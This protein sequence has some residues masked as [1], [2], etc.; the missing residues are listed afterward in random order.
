MNPRARQDMPEM[1]WPQLRTYRYSQQDTGVRIF[2]LAFPTLFPTGLADYSLPRLR[3]KGLTFL[4]WIQHLLRYHD[5]RFA[6]HD[7]FRY[8]AF[9]LW[10]RELS[11]A[12][13]RWV[14]NKHQGQPVSVDDLLANLD[15][16][17]RF[18]NATVRCAVSIKGTRPYWKR[19]GVELSAH[20]Q[21]CLIPQFFFTF[22]AADTQWDSLARQM[23]KYEEWKTQND[24]IR[25]V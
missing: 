17:Q 1:D 25:Y 21:W 15:T 5:G 22:S 18:L 3:S 14:V 8:A 23:P 10:I 16:D 6:Q 4:D 24:E 9:N 2:S 12:R 13:A 19:R 20:I 11:S 7:R